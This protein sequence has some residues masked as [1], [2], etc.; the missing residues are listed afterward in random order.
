MSQ[1][2]DLPPISGAQE[3]MERGFELVRIESPVEPQAYVLDFSLGP[4]PKVVMVRRNNSVAVGVELGHNYRA[5]GWRQLMSFA[6]L[7]RMVSRTI[8][9]ND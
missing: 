1:M 3:A 8:R 2:R 4:S 7:A 5:D 6:I 9:S